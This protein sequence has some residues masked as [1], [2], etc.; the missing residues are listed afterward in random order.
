LRSGGC[1]RDLLGPLLADGAVASRPHGRGLAVRLHLDLALDAIFPAMNN[2]SRLPRLEGDSA[3]DAATAFALAA[4]S[5][6]AL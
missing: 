4:A 1:G 2:L 5:I 6:L 3:R